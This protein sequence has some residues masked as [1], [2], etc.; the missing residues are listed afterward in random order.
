[1]VEYVI[2]TRDLTKKFGKEIAFL[3]DGVTKI[4]KLSFSNDQENF[5]YLDFKEYVKNLYQRK[6]R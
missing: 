1:M 3:V 2:E 4:N 6:N 5:D